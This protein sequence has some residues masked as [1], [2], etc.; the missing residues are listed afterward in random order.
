MNDDRKQDLAE[1]IRGLPRPALEPAADVRIHAQARA[2]FLAASSA[3]A[4]TGARAAARQGRWSR[5]WNR[6]LEP[7][8]VVGAVAGY[9][10]W[11]ATALAA[12]DWGHGFDRAVAA[13][14][15]RPG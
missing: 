2:A 6:T 14:S 9:L 10:A 5:L 11:A 15:E 4:P 3:T 7:V 1:R 8:L 13:R 12:I